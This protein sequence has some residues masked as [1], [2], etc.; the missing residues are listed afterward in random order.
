M[1][2]QELSKPEVARKYR[3]L[4]ARS[5][6]QYQAG[7]IPEAVWVNYARERLS[8]L[9]GKEDTTWATL[10]TDLGI[11]AE[12]PVVVYDDSRANNSARVWWILR[13]R[14]VKDV[15]ILNGGWK[16][17]KSLGAAVSQEKPTITKAGP[18]T[19]PVPGRLATK[20]FVLLA[21]KGKSAQLVDARSE[22][23]YCGDA[24]GAQRTGAIPGAVH[25]EWSD[26]ID[27]RTERFKSPQELGKLFKEKGLDLNRP[28]VTYCQSGGRASVMAF[29][30][31]LMGAKDVRNYYR[32]WGEWAADP[33]TPIEKHTPKE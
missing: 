15:R 14:G 4:D 23:E 32:S 33:L 22:A 29:A 12:T 3:I 25:L 2:A 16:A 24:G 5:Q 11:T 17:W 6:Q 7:H 13:Y 31:E 30:L 27:P 18:G 28:L 21:L 10:L 9:G 8:S 20:D 26:T 1:E 19:T